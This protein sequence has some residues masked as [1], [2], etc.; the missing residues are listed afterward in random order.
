MNNLTEENEFDC[1]DRE[2]VPSMAMSVKQ[3]AKALGISRNQAY[4]LKDTPG[5]P[6]F[7][8]GKRVL[9]NREML[10][11]WLNR[12]CGANLVTE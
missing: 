11:D 6:A 4:E 8:I 9:I 3:M 12:Q 2:P 5:F 1:A 10:Q 7:R